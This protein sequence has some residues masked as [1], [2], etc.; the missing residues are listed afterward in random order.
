M[1]AVV[2]VRADAHIQRVL[3][4]LDRHLNLVAGVQRVL[5]ARPKCNMRN[6]SWSMGAAT[7]VA[8]DLG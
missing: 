8:D 1:Q 2:D 6:T 4:C 3:D 5:Q 7:A